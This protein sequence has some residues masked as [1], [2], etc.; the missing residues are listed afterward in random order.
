MICNEFG[1]GFLILGGT[2]VG[3][4][5]GSAFIETTQE[6]TDFTGLSTV[7]KFYETQK[8]EYTSGNNIV[9]LAAFAGVLALDIFAIID[10]VHVAKVKNMYEQDLKKSGYA[11]EVKMYPSLN[12]S[13]VGNTLQPS[14]GITIAMTF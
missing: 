4:V 7:D 8:Q 13:P 11:L 9:A 2:I 10:G 12:F 1:R 5:L 3:S 6:Y 14:A